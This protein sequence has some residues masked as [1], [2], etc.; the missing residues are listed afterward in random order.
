MASSRLK[1]CVR[2]RDAVMTISPSVVS[3]VP[4]SFD[5]RALTGA[6]SDGEPR[7]SNRS[8]AAVETLLTFCPPGPEARMKLIV[9]SP[10]SSDSDGVMMRRSAISSHARAAGTDAPS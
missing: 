8:C 10:G 2:W 1:L 9:I 6:G 7:R 3:F 4:A 5:A